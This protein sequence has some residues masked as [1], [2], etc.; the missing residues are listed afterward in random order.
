MLVIS[1]SLDLGPPDHQMLWAA[2]FW[3]TSLQWILHRPHRP[4]AYESRAPRQTRP[5]KAVFIRIGLDRHPLCAVHA[6][7]TFPAFRGYSSGP[8]L[9]FANGSLSPTLF[10]QITSAQ[11]PGNSFSPSF[12]IGAATVAARSGILNQWAIGPTTLISFVLGHWLTR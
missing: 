3:G 4:C 6:M 2:H 9:L 8:L 10:L 12:R 7:M 5:G 1:Q 11:I